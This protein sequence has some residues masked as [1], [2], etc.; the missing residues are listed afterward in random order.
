MFTITGVEPHTVI[1]I[2]NHATLF[3]MV[4]MASGIYDGQVLPTTMKNDDDVQNGSHTPSDR[5]TD[6]QCTSLILPVHAIMVNSQQ[7]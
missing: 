5:S 4:N 7:S 2:E 3:F 1:E 6:I